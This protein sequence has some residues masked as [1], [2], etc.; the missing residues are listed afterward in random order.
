PASPSPGG[1]PT[2]RHAW[3]SLAAPSRP[4]ALTSIRAI[5]TTRSTRRDAIRISM[6]DAGSEVGH[7][8]SYAPD[9]RG[10]L[11]IS[12]IR[13]RRPSTS[14]IVGRDATIERLEARLHSV[15]PSLDDRTEELS[16]ARA[17]RAAADKEL[18]AIQRELQRSREELSSLHEELT[19]V[20][21][22]LASS[23]REL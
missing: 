22:E 8:V 5:A 15:R 18:Q 7:G 12:R 21:A 3:R 17:D 14:V 11:R 10:A 6:L 13:S 2:A 4:G 9:E 20:N 23:Y 1:G 19:A 16:L